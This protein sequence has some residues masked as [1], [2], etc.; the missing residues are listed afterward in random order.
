MLQSLSLKQ[1]TDS[2]ERRLC[3]IKDTKHTVTGCSFAVVCVR[4][5]RAD[6]ASSTRVYGKHRF[7]QYIMNRDGNEVLGELPWRRPLAQWA[8]VIGAWPTPPSSCNVTIC[9]WCTNPIK[10]ECC[11]EFCWWR[12]K[13]PSAAI[14]CVQTPLEAWKSHITN[15]WDQRDY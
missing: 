7:I 2:I 4:G 5:S 8:L 11:A 12:L 3:L 13:V 1:T 6:S 9:V 14:L 10:C 15:W